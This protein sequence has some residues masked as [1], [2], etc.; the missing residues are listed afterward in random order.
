MKI[1]AKTKLKIGDVVSIGDGPGMT[2]DT[3]GRSYVLCMWFG[4]NTRAQW[5]G[6][7]RRR[8]S[9]KKITHVWRESAR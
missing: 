2:V 7:H 8:F 4:I 5:T 1:T 3:I 9:R 6:P